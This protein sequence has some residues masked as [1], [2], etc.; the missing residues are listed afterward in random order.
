MLLGMLL[1]LCSRSQDTTNGKS[2]DNGQRQAVS[3]PE[4]YFSQIQQKSRLLES[5]VHKST[6]KTLSRLAREEKRMQAKLSRID[7]IAARNIFSRSIDSLNGLRTSMRQK[8][9][10][11]AR[12]LQGDYSG[13]LDTLQGSLKFLNESKALLEKTKG[14]KE[15]LNGS[16]KSVQQ[17]QQKLQQAEQVKAF[18]RERRQQLKEQLSQY[19]GFTKDLQRL[20]KE[21]YYYAAQLKE[22]KELFK[23]RKK[24]EAKA[25]ELLQQLPAYNDF[26]KKNSHLAGLFNL[27]PT[28]GSDVAQSLVGLQTRTQVEQLLQQR[29]SGAG[30]DARAA[31][32]Q[33][34]DAARQQ[35]S[36]L[37]NKF[38]QLDNAA[39]MPDFKPSEMRSKPFLRRLEFG[40]NLQF[41]RSNK[42][43][44]TTTD[45]AGQLAYKF[46][47]NG[48]AGIGGVYRLG[49]GTG[50][51]N[52]RFTHQGAGIRSFLDW[53]LKGS[54]FVN[55]GFE[56]NY[57]TN[58]QN[59]G[60]LPN[61]D[62]WQSSALIGI[63][64]KYRIN[65]KL[66]GNLILL[67]DFLYNQHTP[68]TDP[69][70][71]RLGYTL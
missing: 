19:T 40:G 54:F 26:L 4:K 49:L 45:I 24:A 63:S 71:L 32:S 62:H 29:L 22:Y 60:Q 67:Y 46:H 64:K 41:Q 16:L 12:M 69:I 56:Q 14:M 9:G 50:F 48:S 35:F 47:K 28:A 20:H 42:Y 30:P 31:I 10:K 23:D 21:A 11:Y 44:P 57:N 61:A 7:S 36:D 51:D 70:K 18:I 33:Q 3:L 38:P 39:E 13:Y 34:M 59:L 66:K 17:L 8:T 2:I 65:D 43:F 27:T 53:K 58:F 37:K 6:E 68:R 5:R 55:G 1:S 52:I 15:K 25:M